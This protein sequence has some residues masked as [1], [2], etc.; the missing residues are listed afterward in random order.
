MPERSKGAVCKTAG[1]AY[2][3]SNP[4]P[5]ISMGSRFTSRDPTRALSGRRT[6]RR[7]ASAEGSPGATRPDDP[8]RTPP[9]APA[10][11]GL[12]S[13]RLREHLL[14]GFRG[15][16]PQLPRSAGGTARYGRIHRPHLPAAT[17]PGGAVQVLA[18][19][20]RPALV[21]RFTAR[22]GTVGVARTSFRVPAPVSHEA[23]YGDSVSLPGPSARQEAGAWLTCRRRCIPITFSSHGASVQAPDR[24]ARPR[25]RS[26]HHTG[27][28]R[29]AIQG[30][31]AG[32]GPL[33]RTVAP[34]GA[35]PA[36][37]RG[38]M[39]TDQPDPWP[40]AALE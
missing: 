26:Y 39:L 20:K 10:L 1:Y 12:V 8:S 32:D 13:R 31:G 16:P 4:P 30:R 17:A 40:P 14:S 7:S 3:G 15:R 37:S 24:A 34:G 33:A 27:P 25:S 6:P 28:L 35:A 9:S 29:P 36:V 38:S 18:W 19:S 11:G 2:G 23:P 21:R 5:P 22:V